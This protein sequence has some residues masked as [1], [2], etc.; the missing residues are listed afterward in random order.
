MRFVDTNVLLYAVS[1]AADERAKH[2]R[3]LQLLDAE[4]LALSIQVLQVEFL[5][6][7]LEGLY[8]FLA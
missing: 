8:R 7:N 2:E 4:D 5:N 1:T 6:K 3:A